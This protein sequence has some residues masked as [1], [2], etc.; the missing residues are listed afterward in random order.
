[1]EVLGGGAGR[2]EVG[3]ELNRWETKCAC[4]GG[5]V[6]FDMGD[7]FFVFSARFSTAFLPST[8]HKE[9]IPFFLLHLLS[10]VAVSAGRWRCWGGAGGASSLC[11][12]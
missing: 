12:S 4:G 8:T 2:G 10:L 7:L 5:G 1:M 9:L 6:V 3:E 11:R